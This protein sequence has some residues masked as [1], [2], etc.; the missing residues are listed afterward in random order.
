M[1]NAD[2]TKAGQDTTNVSPGDKTRHGHGHGHG[3]DMGKT[4]TRHGH[5]QGQDKDKAW[6]RLTKRRRRHGKL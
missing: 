6:A 4:W 3:Q 2:I 5:G 1:L